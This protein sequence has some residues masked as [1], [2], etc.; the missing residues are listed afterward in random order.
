MKRKL[1]ALM[2]SIVVMLA[3]SVFAEAE[4]RTRKHYP[5]NNRDQMQNSAGCPVR[6]LPDGSLVD[7]RGW[8]KWS[9]SIGWD[10]SCFN[11]DYLPSAFACS[12]RGGRN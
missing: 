5:P 6:Q 1:V 8:R 2:T 10:N 11:L 7:C 4:A 3:A 9:G 12:S